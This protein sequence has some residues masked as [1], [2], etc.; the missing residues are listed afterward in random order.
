MNRRLG[1]RDQ[2]DSACPEH[3]L[4]FQFQTQTVPLFL[5]LIPGSAVAILKTAFDQLK[6]VGSYFTVQARQRARSARA[7]GVPRCVIS[8]DAPPPANA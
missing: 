1:G 4:M 3:A 5:F 2:L 7:V 6:L 8:I